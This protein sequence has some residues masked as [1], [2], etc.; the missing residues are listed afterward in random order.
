MRYKLEIEK[1]TCKQKTDIIEYLI[2]T[3]KETLSDLLQVKEIREILQKKGFDL[4]K[5]IFVSYELP[6][7]TYVYE[8]IK[9]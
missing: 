7:L 5:K 6:D 9:T 8:Q 4:D 1:L 3:N 2:G